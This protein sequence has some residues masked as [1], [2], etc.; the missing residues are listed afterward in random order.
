MQIQIASPGLYFE[1]KLPCIP[2]VRMNGTIK[3]IFKASEENMSTCQCYT[4]SFLPDIRCTGKENSK[5]L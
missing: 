5:T 2:R 1:G 4:H 3:I